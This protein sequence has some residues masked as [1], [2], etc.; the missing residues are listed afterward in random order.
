MINKIGL[1]LSSLYLIWSIGV[2]AHVGS[3]ANETLVQQSISHN[4]V[5][6]I[7]APFNT[8]L[9][10]VLVM[11]DDTYYEGFYSVFDAD[12]RIDFKSFPIQ[13]RLLDSLQDHWPV[14]R[15]EW[16]THGNYAVQQIE[17]DI[18][19]KDL[20]MGFE[21][22]YV[23]QFKVGEIRG[24]AVYPTNSSEVQPVFDLSQLRLV[25]DR[26]WDEHSTTMHSASM[27]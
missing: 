23:F 21:P 24:G 18:V 12:R 11:D 22:V 7:A 19:I 6:T 15:L 10:R 27:N 5:L 4:Q 16:F 9:W 3:V 2:K 20:R 1:G 14:K 17:N 26:I 8:L 13:K 25:W